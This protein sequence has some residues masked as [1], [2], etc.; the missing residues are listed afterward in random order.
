MKKVEV[1][2]QNDLVEKLSSANPIVALSEL[3]WNS[4]DADADNVQVFLDY[5][6]LSTLEGITVK[7]DGLGISYSEAETFFKNLGG[8]WKALR[9]KT[10]SKS[11]YLHG[12][13]GRGRLKAFALGRVC[14]WDV[15]YKKEDKH[16]TYYIEIFSD[17]IKVANISEEK[18]SDSPKTGVT[19]SIKEVNKN[20][21]SLKAENATQPLCEVFALYLNM[22]KGITISYMGQQLDPVSLMAN[23]EEFELAEI[24][25]DKDTK[26]KVSL[27]LIEWKASN[28]KNLY[29]C[30]T[31]GFPFSL[32]ENRRFNTGLHHFTGYLKSSLIDRL[33][34]ENSLGMGT[35]NPIVSDLVTEAQKKIREYF[36][37][38]DAEVAQS[39][40]AEWKKEEIYPYSDETGSPIEEAERQVFDIV[41]TKVNHHLPDFQSSSKNSKKLSLKLLKQA[42][43]KS[44]DE[45]ELILTE[46]L[47]LPKKQQKDLAKLLKD[48]SLTAIINVSKT[49]TDRLNFLK[50]IEEIVFDKDLKK[51]VKE[52][53]Q[54]HKIIEDNVWL[55]GERFN[56]SASDKSLTEVL[57]NHKKLLGDK[58]VIDEPVK[59]ID[60]KTGI[61]DLMLTRSIPSHK[62]DEVEQLIIEL[63]APKVKIGADE[64]A[65]I[66]KYAFTI[67]DDERF[68]GVTSNWNFWVISDDLDAFTTKKINQ[69]DRASGILF[70]SDKT[71]NPNVTVWVK[72][73]GQILQENKSRL[74]SLKE[75]LA[76]E[77]DK[78]EALKSLQ[79]QY[80]QIFKETKVDKAL[81]V[82][83]KGQE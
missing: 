2:I 26:H 3:I 81:E 24:V 59:R 77:A 79:S 40:V 5:D 78:G 72:T 44:P 70:E 11:R 22:Y 75:K 18:E 43:E 67:A 71:D 9:S 21:T 27:E 58:T 53:S 8:S 38:K 49:I 17:N 57:K 66:E 36:N 37:L 83:I 82:K 47:N 31:Q 60:G 35:M 42:I 51:Y 39:I 7:D 48:T 33:N 14:R 62:P 61:V 56:L 6:A 23:R 30:G 28:D 32:V 10:K 68:R 52:R 15:V 63:K 55:F 54:L 74:S 76:Y 4:L 16:F 20:Y 1:E 19:V 25:D 73:W 64:C 69:K 65:Q 45:L 50:G 34:Q 12:K 41:A 13:E 80:K 46:V 29:L